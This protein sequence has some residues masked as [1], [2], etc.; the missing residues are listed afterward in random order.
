MALR[1]ASRGPGTVRIICYVVG[2]VEG[3]PRGFPEPTAIR[4]TAAAG[5]PLL[6]DGSL[7]RL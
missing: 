2:E 7:R 3:S 4:A 1:S 6:K 5:P